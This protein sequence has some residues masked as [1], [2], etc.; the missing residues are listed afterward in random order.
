M[1]RILRA[2]VVVVLAACD[3]P[4]SPQAAAEKAQ[5]ADARSACVQLFERQRACT[6]AFIPALVDLR[7]ELDAPTGIA[8]QPRADV[9]AAALEEWKADSTDDA[10]AGQCDRLAPKLAAAAV[11]EAR[12]CVAMGPCGEFVRCVMPLTRAHLGQ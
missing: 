6:D 7:R 5:L 12:G 3:R 11:A 4:D 8:Q 2:A 1:N 10:L 9:V